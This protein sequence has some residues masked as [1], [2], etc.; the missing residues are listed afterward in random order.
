[1]QK[2]HSYVMGNWYYG[3]N[4]PRI[5]SSALTNER[6]YELDSSGIDNAAMLEYG[7]KKGSKALASMTFLERG[8]MLKEVAK[9][10]LA[11]KEELYALS[12]HTGATRVDS[13]IDI[14]GG[15]A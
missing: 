3:K 15:A 11:N 4:T 12:A 7:R 10:L 6:L 2:L 14:E 8:N 1:M 5:T 13:W 9:Y